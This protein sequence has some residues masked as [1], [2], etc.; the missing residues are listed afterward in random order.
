MAPEPPSK[1]AVQAEFILSIAAAWACDIRGIA[2]AGTSAGPGRCVGE[3]LST[4]V[5]QPSPDGRSASSSSSPLDVASWIL[6]V[7]LTP[8]WP[9]LRFGANAASSAAAAAAGISGPMLEPGGPCT[10]CKK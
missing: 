6:E 2:G 4:V 1:W 10:S 7:D 5:A 3:V 9:P 8:G